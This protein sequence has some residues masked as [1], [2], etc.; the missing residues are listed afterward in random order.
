M[1]IKDGYVLRKI[2]EEYIVIAVGE[3]FAEFSGMMSLNEVSAKIWDYLSKERTFGEILA[4]V[5][6][7][8]DIDEE[9]AGTD[10]NNLLTQMESAGVL[11]NV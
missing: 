6:S 7:V 3:R 2:A 10:I 11:D 9:T 5:L 8:Y 1:K 4:Y